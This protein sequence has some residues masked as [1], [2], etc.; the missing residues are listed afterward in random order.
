M[1]EN[2]DFNKVGKKLPY[3]IPDSFLDGFTYGSVRKSD[4]EKRKYA[5]KIKF[6]KI[7]F[8]AA[9][10]VLLL[11]TGIHFIKESEVPEINIS[12]TNTV[13]T[14]GVINKNGAEIEAIIR[15]LSDEELMILSSTIESDMFNEL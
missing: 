14:Q 3:K 15:E 5:G 12:D 6:W 9:S 13:T 2:L 7:S 1:K 11:F 4:N 8:A 10:V